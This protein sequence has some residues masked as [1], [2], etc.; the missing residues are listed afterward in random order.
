M[1]RLLI[2]MILTFVAPL[3]GCSESSAPAGENGLTRIEGQVYAPLEGAYL[4]VYR[5]GMD[6]HGPA[7]VVSRASDQDGRFELSLPEGDYMA[8]VRKRQSGETSGPVVAGDHRSEMIPLKVRGGRLTLNVE[9]PRKV[10]D[11]R[12][13]AQDQL[14]A[15]TGLSGTILDSEGR[16][17]E[18]ARVHVYD[19][20]QM[21]E[22]PKYVSEQTGPDGRYLIHLPEGG[23]YY[24]AARDRFGGP[25]QI[26][27]L[28]GRYDQGTIEPSAVILE[29]GRILEDVD[30]RVTK[31]W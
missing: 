17:V 25:P 30:I 13:L 8:V 18:G 1:S 3:G 2:L 14:A 21:S 15:R 19:H 24:L 26:G 9:A 10:G 16:P 4:Y 12:L 5:Q 28:Y 11:E 31:V 23:T 29:E 7:Y 22:R 27:D 20:V 6:L